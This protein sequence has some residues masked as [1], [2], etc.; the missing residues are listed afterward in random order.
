[1]VLEL[2]EDLHTGKKNQTGFST[3]Y[4]EINSWQIK[5]LNWNTNYTALRWYC[6]I[7]ISEWARIS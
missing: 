5:I 4:T 1:M 2:A 7:Y 3:K 6:K